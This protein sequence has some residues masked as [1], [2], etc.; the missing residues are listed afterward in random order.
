MRKT[1]SDKGVAALRPRAERFAFPDPELRGH[2]VRVQPSGSKAFV[3]AARDPFGKQIWVTLGNTDAMA[4]EQARDQAR[5]SLK[6]IKDGQPAVEPP[7]VQPDSFRSVAENWLHRHVAKEK[8]RTQPEIERCLAKYVFPHLADRAFTSIRRS[9]ITALLDYVEDNHGAR[10]ADLVLAT[11]RS[12]ANWYATR[13]DDYLSPFTRGMRRSSGGKR[14]RILTDDELQAVWKEAEASGRFGALIRV[15]LLTGQRRGAAVRMRWSD[16]SADGTWTIPK[17]DREKGNAGSLAL[18]ARA[19]SI[20]NAQPRFGSNPYVFSASRGDG[21]M[22]GF[23]HAKLAFDKACG[24]SG[25][26]LHDLRRTSRSLLSRC[27]IAHETAERI[28][29]HVVGSHVSQIYDR[30][31]YDAEKAAALA[32]LA[33]LIDVIVDPRDNVLPLTKPRKKNR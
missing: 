20:I 9:D 7:P 33:A 27:G 31:P 12:I 29:G 14:S 16:I 18:P 17:A 32:K 30:H 19:L 1:L 8:L 6:R 25:W 28:L 21:P 3:V 5:V 23:S 24:V 10:Q 4:I 26:T 22:Y 2:Y 15:L 13:N 11:V